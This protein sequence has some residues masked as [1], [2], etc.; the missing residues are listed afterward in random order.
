MCLEKNHELYTRTVI[1]RNNLTVFGTV[2]ELEKFFD[3]WIFY[4]LMMRVQR[5]GLYNI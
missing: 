1:W 4:G 5:S 2:A 3:K